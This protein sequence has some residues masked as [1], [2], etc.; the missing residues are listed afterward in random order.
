M[1]CPVP[2]LQSEMLAISKARKYCCRLMV[3]GIFFCRSSA[4]GIT[5]H[6]STTCSHNSP[7]ANALASRASAAAAGCPCVTLCIP[8]FNAISAAPPSCCQPSWTPHGQHW[9]IRCGAC[10][11]MSRISSV[12]SILFLETHILYET[13]LGPPNSNMEHLALICI[14]LVAA[15]LE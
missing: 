7:T 9:C 3:T 10:F 4:L 15:Y 2:I 8:F 13:T 1:S 14:L 5:S 11:S 6:F 12:A